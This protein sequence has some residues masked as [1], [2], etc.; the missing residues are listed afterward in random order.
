MVIASSSFL[1]HELC[2]VHPL[3]FSL[4]FKLFMCILYQFFIQLLLKYVLYC[5][6]TPIA[7]SP[8]L[9]KWTIQC[10]LGVFTN[11]TLLPSVHFQNIFVTLKRNP[12]TLH[13]SPPTHPHFWQPPIK[14]LPLWICVNGIKPHV[15]F[16]S[17]T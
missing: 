10:F 3:S 1:H 16:L 12:A 4:I 15:V 13:F 11:Y 8:T 17:C 2:S 14:L 5:N 9:V 7:R 6:R